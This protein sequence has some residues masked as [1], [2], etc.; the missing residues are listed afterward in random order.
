M[1]KFSTRVMTTANVTW[2]MDQNSFYKPNYPFITKKKK[3]KKGGSKSERGE[4]GKWKYE[5]FFLKLILRMML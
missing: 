5:R 4:E 1:L 3:K 2:L